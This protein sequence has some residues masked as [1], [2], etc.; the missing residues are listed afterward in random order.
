M[1]TKTYT[2]GPV[3]FGYNKLHRKWNFTI[4]ENGATRTIVASCPGGVVTATKVAN[5]MVGSLKRTK[6]NGIDNLARANVSQIIG[7]F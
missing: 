6:N 7:T 5:V 2:N 4:P 1:N 3:T